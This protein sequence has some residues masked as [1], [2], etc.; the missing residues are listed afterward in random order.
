MSW[1]RNCLGMLVFIL[2]I[3]RAGIAPAQQ[4]DPALDIYLK[5]QTLATLPDGRHIHLFCLGQGEP[6]AIIA[7]G[8]HIPAIGWNRIQPL[9]AKQ[10]RV[11]V[12]DRAG[13]S[14]SD[15]GPMPR[16]T[17]AEVKDLHNALK[18]AGLAGPYILVGHS[19]GGFDA[20]LFAYIYPRETAGLLLLDPPTERIFQHTREPDEDIGLMKRCADLVRAAPLAWERNN[21][22]LD[23]RVGPRWPAAMKSKLLADQ[24]HVSWFETLVSE[25]VS[26]VTRSA[27][28]LVAARR[29]LGAIP[30]ILLQADTNCP[31]TQRHTPA[32]VQF[33]AQRC[34]ELA[35]Q[36]HDST[37]GERRIVSGASHMIQDDKPEVVLDAF[38]ET[39]RAAR[40]SGLATAE[41][42]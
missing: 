18:S 1:V 26:M 39:L 12:Y 17:A 14:F 29:R 9:M 31:S 7:P 25:D 5:P 19:L 28:E 33:D 34:A 21:D 16:D 3:S 10:T 38:S 15:P 37:R 2:S 40:S 22:C 20:R 30:L 41:P 11:C 8:W 6:V 13:Y 36:A 27:D 32:R 24:N 42:R 23:L 4:P 35:G